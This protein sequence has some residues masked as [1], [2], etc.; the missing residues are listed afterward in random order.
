MSQTRTIATVTLAAAL[1]LGLSGCNWRSS[2]DKQADLDKTR[3]EVAKATEK[4]KPVI[5]D[6][7]RKLGEAAHVAAEQAHAAAQ[8]VREGWKNSKN[9][10]VDINS[11]TAQ[12]LMTLPGITRPQA[13]EIIASRPFDDKHDL[14]T[15]HILSE[16]AYTRIRDRITA[17]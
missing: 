8:G 11:A 1:L 12:R 3:D 14:V 6:A 5:E 7:G 9:P 16:S 10:P 13:H 15:K 17:K 4:A 2:D